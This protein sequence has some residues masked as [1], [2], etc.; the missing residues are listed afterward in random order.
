VV[1]ERRSSPPGR[2]ECVRAGPSLDAVWTGE[3]GPGRSS[4]SFVRTGRE[5]ASR[6]RIETAVL[7]AF[8]T[9]E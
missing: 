9:M 4:S 6:D 5:G 8:N 1:L 2:F 3:H 7:T